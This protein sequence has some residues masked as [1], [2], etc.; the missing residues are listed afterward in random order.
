MFAA[1]IRVTGS[2]IEPGVPRTLFGLLTP[3]AVLGHAPYHRFA[4]TADG[5]RFLVSQA[6]VGGPTVGGLADTIAA[7]ADRGGTTATGT[8]NAVTVILNWTQLLKKK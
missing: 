7:V 4:V 1:D 8:P 6:G 2:S 3:S 5:Q